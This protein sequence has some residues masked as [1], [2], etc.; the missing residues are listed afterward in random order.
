[1]PDTTAAAGLRAI[2][3]P[4]TLVRAAMMRFGLGSFETRL[5]LDAFRRPWYAYGM[6]EAAD[7]AR[8]LKLPA[9]TAIEFGVAG[10][11]GLVEMEAIAREL[12]KALGVQIH[13]VG[14]DTGE[15]MPEEHDYR[16]LPYIWKR[17][18]YKMDV[19][20]VKSRLSRAELVLGNVARTVP[21]ILERGLAGPIG[22]AVFDLDYYSSTV[23]AFRIFDGPVGAYLPRVLCYFDDIMSG[24]QMYHCEE[25]G[26]LLAIREFNESRPKDQKIRPA[27]NLIGSL[28][29]RPA[30]AERI[31]VHHR[32]EHPQYETYIGR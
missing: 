7:L 1:M 2:F 4:L 26:E 12:E 17:G 16:D 5:A 14:F 25:V 8:R 27:H 31:W 11:D 3:Q 9:I 32:F 15:G 10:G 28:P 21:S 29:M 18:L 24:T 19:D 6:Y 30:W 23:D 20:H 13:V 22:F